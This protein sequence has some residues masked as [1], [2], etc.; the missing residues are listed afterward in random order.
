MKTVAITEMGISVPAVIAGCMRIAGLSGTEAADFISTAVDSG[1]TFFDHAD[2]YGSGQS[3]TVFGSALKQHSLIK[4]QDII[5]QSKCG[6]RKGCYDL[7]KEYILS[8]I[9][10]ILSRL[11]TDYLDILLLHRPDALVEPEET[12]A[13]F[14]KLHETGKVRF[15]GVSNHNS[16]QIQLLQKYTSLPLIF[17]QLQFSLPVSNMVAAG[18]EVNM[19]TAGSVNRDG[20]I[21]D[22]CRL[23]GITIQAWSPFQMPAW[24]GCFIGNPEYPELNRVLQELGAVYHATPTQ[25]AAAWILRHPAQMQLVTGTT[26]P[27]RLEEIAAATDIRLSREDWYR[28]YLAAGHILP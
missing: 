19:E 17:N 2:I 14:E 6:I 12:A 15:F 4:R 3:E 21:L 18:M 13:A 8:S 20:S 26:K 23:N 27:Q 28:L 1:I 22:Y 10:G 25:I 11:Q 16:L 7:S 5:I 24:K 9:N